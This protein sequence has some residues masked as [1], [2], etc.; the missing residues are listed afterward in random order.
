MSRNPD[1]NDRR[2]RPNRR[3]KRKHVRIYNTFAF[4]IS[5]EKIRELAE[6]DPKIALIILE[7][8]GRAD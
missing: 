6:Q 4:C 8:Q 5:D 2:P 1:I 3:P 7:E